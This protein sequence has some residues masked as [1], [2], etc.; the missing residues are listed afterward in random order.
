MVIIDAED[1]TALLKRLESVESESVAV[2]GLQV[3][4]TTIREVRMNTEKSMDRCTFNFLLASELRR[5]AA[6]SLFSTHF[7]KVDAT[8]LT[9]QEVTMR[10][11][12]QGTLKSKI[13]VIS[14]RWSAPG[15]PDPDGAQEREIKRY[16]NSP[17]GLEIELVWH[18]V[19][20]GIR[21][22]TLALPKCLSH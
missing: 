5:E 2:I 10:D 19:S 11:V 1:A 15:Q 18:D 17:E 16:L 8:M 7:Q 22:G 9:R 13:L 3:H 14:H 20:A 12:L 6:P 21:T 4:N